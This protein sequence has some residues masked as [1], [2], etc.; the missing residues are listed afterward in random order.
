MFKQIEKG[1]PPTASA[2]CAR[3]TAVKCFLCKECDSVQS[4]EEKREGKAAH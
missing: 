2:F 3:M 1:T 4:R